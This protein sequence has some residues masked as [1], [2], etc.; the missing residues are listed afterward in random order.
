MARK[1]KNA[2]HICGKYVKKFNALSADANVVVAVLSSVGVF[3]TCW[4]FAI[5]TFGSLIGVTFGWIPA[6][7]LASAAAFVGYYLWWLVIPLAAIALLR[8]LA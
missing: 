5:D 2:K 7:V 8:W 6:A 4:V 1:S 3:L